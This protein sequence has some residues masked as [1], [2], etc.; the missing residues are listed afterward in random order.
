MTEAL[1]WI[2]TALLGL[3]VVL[4]GSLIRYVVSVEHRITKLEDLPRRVN[5]LD[6][7]MLSFSW[8]QRVEDDD[9][10]GKEA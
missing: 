4:L 6:S 2:N 7:W 3:L 8:R 10:K 1:P 9:L 5:V